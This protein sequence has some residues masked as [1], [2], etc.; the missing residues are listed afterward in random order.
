L[1]SQEKYFSALL[2]FH[3]PPQHYAIHKMK[4]KSRLLCLVVPS[5]D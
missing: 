1:V 3:P 2:L 5:R 4:K